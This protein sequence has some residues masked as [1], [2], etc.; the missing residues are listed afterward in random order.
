MFT[1]SSLNDASNKVFVFKDG[2]VLHEIDLDK[3]LGPGELAFIQECRE[4]PTGTALI[5]GFGQSIVFVSVD[6]AT[7]KVTK[8]CIVFSAT[9]WVRLFIVFHGIRCKAVHS[10][11]YRCV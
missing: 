9:G 11:G 10:K 2:E 1:F 5:T 3:Q 6:L 8:P 4:G 7:G